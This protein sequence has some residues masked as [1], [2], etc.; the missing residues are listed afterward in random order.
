MSGPTS[1]P[2]WLSNTGAN[3]NRNGNALPNPNPQRQL[4]AHSTPN[5]SFNRVPSNTSNSSSILRNGSPQRAPPQSTGH[6]RIP[7][8]LNRRPHLHENSRTLSEALRA[9]R[10]RE[11][12]E[13]LL[14]DDEVSNPDGVSRDAEGAREPREVFTRDPHLK[15]PVYYTIQR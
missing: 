5:I 3:G 2:N 11:E 14:G 15:L 8:V 4:H 9:V 6:I 10:S 7:T 12:Q 13:T 1:D